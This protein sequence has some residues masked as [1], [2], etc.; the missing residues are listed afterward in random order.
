MADFC[1]VL[2]RLRTSLG[3]GSAR[4]F[5]R[6][7]GG[8]AFFGC[9]Y[10]AYLNVEGGRS[11]P[12]PHLALKIAA[13]LNLLDETRRHD[14]VEFVT[15]YLRS[16]LGREELVALLVRMLSGKAPSQVETS[17]FRKASERSMSEQTI[18]LTRKQAELQLRSAEHYWAFTLLQDDRRHWEPA[19]IASI[20][21]LRRGK[22]VAA[23]R[24]LEGGELL[25]E[26]KDGRFYCPHA[27]KVFIYPRDRFYASRFIPA[28]KGHWNDMVRK[29]GAAVFNSCLL[30]RAGE[31]DLKSYFPTL[32]QSVYGAH[33]YAVKE[34]GPDTAFFT[35]E[36]VVRKL[37]PF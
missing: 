28:M 33:I 4:A 9:T 11:L 3:H 35:I 8:A 34:K 16:L 37:L 26:D 2:R 13:G 23:L 1:S 7:Q 14:A 25:A 29:R 30:V 12:Q 24:E 5:F 32:A 22:L 6:A 17:M 15:A 31:A 19:E 10:K 27:G 36:A 20:L 21:G 18:P